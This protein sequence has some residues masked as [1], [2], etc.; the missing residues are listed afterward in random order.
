MVRAVTSNG[1]MTA[2]LS[3]PTPLLES[4]VM[5]AVDVFIVSRVAE[6][7]RLQCLRLALAEPSARACSRP[8]SPPTRVEQSAP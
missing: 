5:R 3:K 8:T 6:S 2:R 4:S 1:V 7:N